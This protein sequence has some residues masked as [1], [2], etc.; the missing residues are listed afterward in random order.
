MK[1]KRKADRGLFR[2]RG[3]PHWWIRYADQ[4]GRIVRESTNTTVKKLAREILAKKKVL[5]A[6]GRHLDVKKI[7]KTT[8][9]ELCDQYWK[10]E[11]KNKRTK[12]L[13]NILKIWKKAFGNIPLRDL[14]Q[15]RVEKF[16]TERTESEKL[17]PA[18]RNRHLAM[19]SSLFN[20][21]IE[22]EIAV[23][24]PARGI[25]KLRE[26]GARTRFLDQGEID[27]LLKKSSDDLR[28]ILVV[29]LHTGMRR[30]EIFNLR[31]ADVDLKNRVITVKESKSG[32]KRTIP[33]DDT[34]FSTLRGLS[35]RFTK[36]LVFPA[37]RSPK[38]G[39]EKV[40]YDVKRAFDNALTKA[41]IDD[42]RFHDLRHT[43]ASHLV[44]NGVDV[45]TVQEL[46]GHASL[47]MTMK[48]AHLAPDH[49]ARAIKT[50]DSAYQTDTKTDTVE[51][52]GVS[53]SP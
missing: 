47:T 41:E 30:G 5:V 46:L 27:R 37:P 24:N 34:L 12:G 6:E 52:S 9:F 29:A 17:S 31:W 22:W 35:S 50:L 21:G 43:F 8:F 4:N 48:Y 36:G 28:P 2:R 38:N 19:L 3:S 20:K 1:K 10:L 23:E 44:M 45:K 7:P 11:G 16:L 32:K 42:F 25:K 14:T 51:N 40:R 39:K 15:Q 49:R 33:I 26:K 13:E 53:Q 18:S